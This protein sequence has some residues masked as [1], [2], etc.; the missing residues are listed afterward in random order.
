ME[1]PVEVSGQKLRKIWSK[2]AT[3]VFDFEYGSLVYLW[4]VRAGANVPF[5]HAV[6]LVR[7]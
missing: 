6:E 3:P 2:N 1:A 4:E 5:L 7:T